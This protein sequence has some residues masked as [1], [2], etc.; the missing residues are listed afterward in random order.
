MVDKVVPVAFTDQDS[1]DESIVLAGL[2][3]ET[4]PDTGCV[5]VFRVTADPVTY[6]TS[7]GG[8]IIVEAI[9]LPL[10]VSE[11]IK[12]RNSASSTLS[13]LPT[14]AVTTTWIGPDKGSPSFDGKTVTVPTAVVGVLSCSYTTLY[15]KIC[16]D[17]S[18]SEIL[19]CVT[20]LT[21]TSCQ[22]VTCATT[23]APSSTPVSYELVVKDYC[24]DSVIAGVTVFL[25]AVDIGETDAQ[26]VIPLGG[27]IPGSTHALRM[28]KDGYTA[29]DA[30]NLSNDSFV[31]PTT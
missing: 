24:S 13:Y 3:L 23:T 1:Q 22:S 8:D 31:V 26:G 6:A 12:F 2:S 4:D 11:I 16:A 7:G 9:D 29:S 18:L 19:I 14:G 17:C 25:D 20:Q 15:D 5:R 27:L 10:A 28:T 30:D 21:T